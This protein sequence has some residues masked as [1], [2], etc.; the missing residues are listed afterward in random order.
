MGGT[1]TCVCKCVPY[2]WGEPCFD[3]LEALLAHAMLSIPATKAFE[4]GSGFNGCK[5]KGSEHND[6]F[7]PSSTLNLLCPT[8]FPQHPLSFCPL[9]TETNRS[10]G[11]QGGISNGQEIVFRVGFKPPA[12]ILK[13]QKSSDWDGNIQI[14]SG[15]GRHDPCI[16]PRAVPIVESMCCLVL[17]DCAMRHSGVSQFSPSLRDWNLKL[18]K[19]KPID[20]PLEHL[21]L[22]E[23]PINENELNLS[24]EEK[25]KMTI[26]EIQ[27]QIKELQQKLEQLQSQ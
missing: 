25:R 24:K 11:I 8:K 10:G 7:V 16:V 23:E 26:R 17:M 6:V 27:N 21:T 3:K 5:M 14:L 22:V 2:G 12:T 18:E 20:K 15:K 13:E 9:N 19:R 4:I 1:V